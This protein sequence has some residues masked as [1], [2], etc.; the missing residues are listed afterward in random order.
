MKTIFRAGSVL[1]GLGL[2]GISLLTYACSTS[3]GTDTNSGVVPTLPGDSGVAPGAD[4]AVTPPASDGGD[5]GS[6]KDSGTTCRPPKLHRT[7]AGQGVFCPGSSVD[8]GRELYCDKATQQ[9]CDTPSDAGPSTCSSATAACP[10]PDS[11]AWQCEDSTNCAAGK[12]CC[13]A[14]TLTPDS[15]C[16]YLRGNSGFTGTVCRA[17]CAAGETQICQQQ[18][19]CGTTGTCTPFKVEGNSIGACK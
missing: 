14:V 2:V 19:T 10:V 4:G 7:Q 8:G 1:V 13:A 11:I 5:G 15:V 16:G 17:A 12:A 6:S 18:E 3:T 9:C